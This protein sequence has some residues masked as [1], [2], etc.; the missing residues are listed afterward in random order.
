MNDR[1]S[2][3]VTFDIFKRNLV[4]LVMYGYKHLHR[5]DLDENGNFEDRKVVMHGYKTFV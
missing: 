2:N 5:G 3:H 4:E 1:F